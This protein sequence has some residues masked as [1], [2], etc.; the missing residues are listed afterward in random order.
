VNEHKMRVVVDVVI[1]YLLLPS[2]YCSI[3]QNQDLKTTASQIASNNTATETTTPKFG[4]AW[5]FAKQNQE[6]KRRLKLH[7]RSNTV[8][9]IDQRIQPTWISL[10]ASHGERRV[11]SVTR[12]AYIS[13]GQTIARSNIHQTGENDCRHLDR[14]NSHGPEKEGN[15][16][17]TSQRMES[18]VGDRIILTCVLH[19]V[20][21]EVDF[22]NF[23]VQWMVMNHSASISTKKKRGDLEAKTDAECEDE[24]GRVIDVVSPDC[25]VYTQ[26][27]FDDLTE[28]PKDITCTA[29][30]TLKNSSINDTGIYICRSIIGLDPDENSHNHTYELQSRLFIRVSWE[31]DY[32]VHKVI[33]VVIG[34]TMVFL[35]SGLM[36]KKLMGQR[37]GWEATK[38][39]Y[40]PEWPNSVP[41]RRIASAGSLSYFQSKSSLRRPSEPCDII[42]EESDE[43][44]SED[45]SE[46]Q[47]KVIGC[48]SQ[49]KR[50]EVRTTFKVGNG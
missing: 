29:T 9:E 47:L 41:A 23:H 45:E 5:L 11:T 49:S 44:Y 19:K 38:E 37:L 27:P 30:L 14:K 46:T 1:G 3:L 35:V 31:D 10:D 25:K 36:F 8:E 48:M 18:R 28:S 39:N 2:I 43:D 32:Q 42:D 6:R 22:N 50:P 24:I 17:E 4:L 21:H 7:Q 15:Y 20:H 16:P 12:K 40:A 34:L 13:K 26:F 33:A